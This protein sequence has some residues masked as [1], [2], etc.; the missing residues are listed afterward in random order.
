M[1]SSHR[2]C[3]RP[4]S[5][6]I[7]SGSG[8][9]YRAL[10]C[11]ALLSITLLC[12]A[13]CD[14]NEAAPVTLETY[15]AASALSFSDQLIACAG[16]GAP[17]LIERPD[18][19]VSVYYYPTAGAHTFRYFETVDIHADP[20]ELSNYTEVILEDAPLF[21]GYLRRFR[22]IPLAEEKWARVSFEKGDSLHVSNAIRLKYPV[23]PTEYDDDRVRVTSA[24]T[25]PT[26]SWP[27]HDNESDAIYFQVVADRNGTLISGTYTYEKH[28]TFYDLSNVVLNIRDVSPPPA[29]E[30]DTEYSFTLMTVSSDNW[31]NLIAQ[32]QFAT[33]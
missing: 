32:K 26:F 23:Q 20:S 21:N 27:N 25:T 30:P 31:V 10:L 7:H 28:F 18:A 8:N 17:D 4:G 11:I 12:I 13:G 29:L 9:I 33:E 24:G 1:P 19:P 16:G 5:L 14:S 22:N 3:L 2:V 6:I 15:V